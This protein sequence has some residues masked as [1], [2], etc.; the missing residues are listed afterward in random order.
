[1]IPRAFVQFVR[2]RGLEQV[3]PRVELADQ[4]ESIAVPVGEAADLVAAIAGV[5]DEREPASRAANQL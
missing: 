3:G 4:R 1:V 5:A 2:R